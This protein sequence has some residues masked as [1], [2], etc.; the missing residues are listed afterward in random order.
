MN[1]SVSKIGRYVGLFRR[2][3]NIQKVYLQGSYRITKTIKE[4][5]ATGIAQKSCTPL[6]PLRSLKKN[7]ILKMKKE[8]WKH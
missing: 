3:T 7:D 6:F 2:H 5:V 8:K 1:V 4:F